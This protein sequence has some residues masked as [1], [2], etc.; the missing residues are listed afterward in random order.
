MFY[1]MGRYYQSVNDGYIEVAP[2]LGARVRELPPN[3]T[4]YYS[5]GRRIYD[6]QDAYYD[7]DGQEYVVINRPV[8]ERVVINAGDGVTIT[9]SSLN[10]RRGPGTQYDV[11]GVLYKG[12]VVEVDGVENGWYYVRLSNG[13]F[14]W[15]SAKYTTPYQ[16][17]DAPRG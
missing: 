3:C 10:I 13:S 5:N 12:N 6:C 14:G 11:I 8:E 4:T 1:S 2:P 15:I 16:A 9:I 7:R 17:Y